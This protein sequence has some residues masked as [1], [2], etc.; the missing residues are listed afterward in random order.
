M[1]VYVKRVL[2]Q[3]LNI[4]NSIANYTMSKNIKE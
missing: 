1:H 3:I 2:S 4:Y